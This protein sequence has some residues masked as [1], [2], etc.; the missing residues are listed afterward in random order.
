MIKEKSIAEKFNDVRL[1]V[2]CQYGKEIKAFYVSKDV[3][4]EL[5]KEVEDMNPHLAFRTYRDLSGALSVF[6]KPVHLVINAGPDYID[7]SM[8]HGN[9]LEDLC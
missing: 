7:Y 2:Q 1:Y 6:G 9:K 4:I 3:F 8:V 5:K